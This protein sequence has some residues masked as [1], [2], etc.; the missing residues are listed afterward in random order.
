MKPVTI[1]DLSTLA[2]PLAAINAAIE[3]QKANKINQYYPETG[4]LRRELY[5]KHCAVFEAGK[6]YRTRAV[7]AGNRSGKALKNGSLVA[8]PNGWWPIEHLI[9]GDSVFAGDGSQ[10]KVIGVYPQGIKPLVDVEF[11]RGEKITTC[12]D[13][14]WKS[15]GPEQRF[16]KSRSDYKEWGIQTSKQI[17]ERTTNCAR[18]RTVVPTS[19]A[20]RMR[21]KLVGIH[22]YLLGL[23][24]GDGSLGTDGVS[25]SSKDQELLDYIA[26]LI[27]PLALHL[28][29]QKSSEARAAGACGYSLSRYGGNGHSKGLTRHEARNP[30]LS[31]LKAEWLAGTDCFTKQIPLNYLMNSA[32]IRIEMLRGLMDTDGSITKEGSCE[33]S[34]SSQAMAQ[35]VKFL[36]SSFGGKCTI[37]DRIPTYEY[38]GQKLNGAVSYRV[39]LQMSV[40]PF[41]LSRKVERWARVNTEVLRNTRDRVIHSVTPSGEGECTCIAVD[42]P[43][44]TY[45]T[46]HGIVTHNTEGIGIY[47]TVLHLTGRYPKWWTGHRFD[48]PIKAWASGDTSKT[49]KEIIQDKLLGP[50]GSFGTGMIPKGSLVKTTSKAGVADAVDS[51]YVKHEKGGNPSVL[52]LKSY[53]QKREAFQGSEQHWILL[54]EEPD[55]EIMTECAMRTMATGAFP[56]GKL[57]LTFT[58]VNGWTDLV[59]QF[60]ND[61]R[62]TKSHRF[63]MT[64]TWDDAPHLTDKEKAE[65]LAEIPEYQR[66]ARVFGVPELGSGAI[67]PFDE[68]DITVDPFEIPDHWARVCG[69]DVGGKT[70]ATWMAHDRDTDVIYLYAEYYRE[71]TEPGVHAV[72]IKG[73]G[74]VPIY[75]DP[76]ANQSSQIDGRK[77]LQMYRELGLDMHKAD[78]AVESGVL[79]TYNR[80]ASGRLKI[81]KSCQRWLEERRR[82]RRVKGRI[83][84]DFDHLCDAQRYALN[85]DLNN[86]VARKAKPIKSTS[87]ID[88]FA[89]YG[90]SSDNANS[91]MVM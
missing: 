63:V 9:P 65:L 47:E 83:V 20:W 2:D 19:G 76:A 26:L 29:K 75:C 35:Q 7:I 88:P 48:G 8:T 42:H 73:N 52:T 61:E 41:R 74:A 21:S 31:F 70:A 24:L 79:K 12:E 86:W 13:H 33:F 39:H 17:M 10:A 59:D 5:P 34:T 57:L 28:V 66:K 53:D 55:E 84:K 3:I 16:R 60:L 38:K 81:F 68:S 54:D 77:I 89:I 62:R 22:P 91:W 25:F 45:V 72:S 27:A 4:P 15:M 69:L 80:L 46:E 14:L 51:I 30:L 32:D 1:P 85:S 50:W 36:V 87:S 6:D 78:N 43:D 37:A 40:C 56:G 58:P 82:Y 90:N 71:N 67:Y 23:L 18:S 44:H 11:D 49:V 64:I